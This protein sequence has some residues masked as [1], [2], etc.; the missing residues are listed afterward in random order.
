[1]GDI[2]M[3]KEKTN[4]KIVIAAIVLRST[5]IP[6]KKNLDQETN[7]ENTKKNPLKLP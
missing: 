1:M 7:Q 3:T 5:K 2:I 4:Y 6:Y